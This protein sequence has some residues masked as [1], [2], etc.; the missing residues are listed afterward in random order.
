MKE[1]PSKDL[2]DVSGGQVTGDPPPY[3]PAGPLPYPQVPGGPV[4]SPIEYPDPP[5]KRPMNS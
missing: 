3:V 1:L 2:P 4:V 5:S